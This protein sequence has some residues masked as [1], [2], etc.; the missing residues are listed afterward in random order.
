[1]TIGVVRAGRACFGPLS[2]SRVEREP[3]GLAL[4][5]MALLGLGILL[6]LFPQLLTNP[7]SAVILPLAVLGS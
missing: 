6:G 5:A 2:G 4:V 3:V 1:V 7:V